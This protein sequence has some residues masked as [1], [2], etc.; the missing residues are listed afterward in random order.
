MHVQSVQKYC[1]S[2]SNMQIVGFFLPS[3]PWFLSSLR[4]LRKGDGKRARQKF[5]YLMRENNDVCKVLHMH[6]CTCGACI[7]PRTC[8]FLL[9]SPTKPRRKMTEYEVSS[10]FTALNGYF[11]FH[12][13]LKSSSLS[14]KC[15]DTLSCETILLCHK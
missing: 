12:N 10:Q 13:F 1:F 3:S 11:F 4:T 5:A 14:F 2:L 15:L 6:V 9:L 7:S 8:V